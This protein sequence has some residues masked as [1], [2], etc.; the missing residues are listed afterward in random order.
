M[1][2]RYPFKREMSK[3]LNA[4]MIDISRKPMK[5]IENLK[6]EQKNVNQTFGFQSK[7]K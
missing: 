5:S 2:G 4:S 7:L 6:Y 1:E 3:G